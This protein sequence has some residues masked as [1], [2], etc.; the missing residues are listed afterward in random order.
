MRR[1]PKHQWV[2]FT[3]F[4]LLDD[5]QL[6]FHIMEFNGGRPTWPQ[7]VQLLNARFSHRSPTASSVSSPCCGTRAWWTTTPSTSSPY[8]A[9]T[10]CCQNL[11]RFNCTSLGSTIPYA[12]MLP[13]SSRRPSTMRS[14]SPKCMS[15]GMPPTTPW[16][17]S[18]PI[19][20][21][22]SRVSLRRRHCHRWLRQVPH[23]HLH[24]VLSTNP[25][26][27][28]SA[29]PRLRS[30]NASRTRNASNATSC[31]RRVTGNTASNY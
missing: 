7:F 18:R 26:P 28:P 2:A 5:A 20:H 6:W 4:Y 11:S 1:T 9:V 10:R 21:H 30:F 31:S 24:R 12:L 29:S 22:A 14:S 23:G 16:S 19:L 17:P 25:H 13:C 15:S 3:T 27:A 8:P